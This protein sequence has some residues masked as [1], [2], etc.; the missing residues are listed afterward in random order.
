MILRLWD[1]RRC[2][3]PRTRYNVSHLEGPQR[4]GEQASIAPR[5]ADA[6][7]AAAGLIS[8]N[9]AVE[10]SKEIHCCLVHCNPCMGAGQMAHEPRPCPE[11]SLFRA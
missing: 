4:R 3:H 2:A 1:L 9:C 10:S 7:N 6:P 11:G 5:H 8:T